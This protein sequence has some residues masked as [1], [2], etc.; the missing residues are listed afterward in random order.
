MK[1]SGKYDHRPVLCDEVARWLQHRSG[2]TI[3][4]GTVG[5]GGHTEVL[6]AADPDTLVIGMDRDE[7]ALA[8]ATER[9]ARFGERITLVHGDYRDVDEHLDDL[10]IA[11]I[12][13]MLLDLGLSSL[14]L[15]CSER[16]FSFR[17]DGP[18]DMRMDRSRGATAADWLAAS[19]VEEIAATLR[20]YGEERYARRIAAAIEVT[21]RRARIQ[22]TGEL[23]RIVHRAVPQRYFAGPIDPATRTFQALRIL[24]NEE[25]EALSEG[26]ARGFSRLTDGGVFVAI[27]FH[28]LEDRIVKWFFREK[29]APC[30]CPPNL[31]KCVCEK[32]I[33]AEILTKKPIV[34][35]D[36]EVAE[37]PRARSAKLRAARKVI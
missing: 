29:A 24:V 33:E 26:L 10:G 17:A 37:N 18:L 20:A 28:S 30:V 4:D 15:D 3:V 21:R 25:L 36:R 32:Q 13:G 12:D 22:T 27:S 7:E 23:K 2:Q 11:E 6:L 1:N 9:L 34:A 35:S 16:G 5:L 31:P 14:Q 19:S 8:I